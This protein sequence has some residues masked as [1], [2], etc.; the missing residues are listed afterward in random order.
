[1]IKK[2]DVAKIYRQN[3]VTIKYLESLEDV[4]IKLATQGKRY[5]TLDMDNVP[6]IERMSYPA[7]AT[8]VVKF[9]NDYGFSTWVNSSNKIVNVYWDD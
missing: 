2:I 9:F 1:M 7:M 6:G 5:L 8:E 3:N 4:I